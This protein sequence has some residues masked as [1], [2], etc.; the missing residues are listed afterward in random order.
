MFPKIFLHYLRSVNCLCVGRCGFVVSS[1]PCTCRGTRC[2]DDGSAAQQRATY[3]STI[4]YLK[5]RHTTIKIARLR[6]WALLLL[7]K[8]CQSSSASMITRLAFML[9]ASGIDLLAS[10]PRWNSGNNPAM[11]DR[12]KPSDNHNQKTTKQ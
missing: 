8:I 6:I 10:N 2:V 3:A 12:C 1:Y 5:Y 4:L 9:T 11:A 7:Q